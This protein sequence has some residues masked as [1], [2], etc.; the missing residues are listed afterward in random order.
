MLSPATWLTS[1]GLSALTLHSCCRKSKCWFC[2]YCDI[3]YVYRIGKL[4][5]V[6]I[7]LKVAFAFLEVYELVIGEIGDRS[8][9]WFVLNEYCRQSGLILVLSWS[10]F[11]V[12]PE[13]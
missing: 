7:L 1:I 3:Q 2:A 5:V 12:E 9:S 11:F 6:K 13:S 8:A 10:T 4:F